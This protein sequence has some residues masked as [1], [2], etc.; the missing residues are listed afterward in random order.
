MFWVDN[1][2]NLLSNMKLAF[3]E[4]VEEAGFFSKMFSGSG[5]DEKAI[6]DVLIKSYGVLLEIYND[7]LGPVCLS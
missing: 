1:L 7:L 6:K 3:Y 4:H 5:N 2:G